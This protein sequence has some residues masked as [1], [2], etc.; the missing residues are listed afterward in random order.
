MPSPYASSISHHE[1]KEPK[2]R[3]SSV[4]GQVPL[5][6]VQEMVWNENKRGYLW[7]RLNVDRPQT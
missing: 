2:L 1:H 4:G 7:F 3:S 6:V 5:R